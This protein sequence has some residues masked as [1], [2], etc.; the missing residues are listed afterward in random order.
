MN[1]TLSN[2]K[3][4]LAGASSGIG[5]A[6]A[7]LLASEGADVTITGR[8]PQKLA[9]SGLSSAVVDSRNREELDAFFAGIGSFDHLVVSLASRR[10][11][12]PLA[13]LSLADVREGFEEKFFAVAH[14]VQAALPYVTGSI[15]V[16]SAVSAS[17]RMPGTSGIAAVNGALEIMVPIWARELAPVRVNA[18]SPGVIDTPW[19]DFLPAADRAAAFAQYSLQIPL[20]RVG[21]A[22][23]IA[24]VVRS[25]V[26]ATYVTG[27]VIVADG[28]LG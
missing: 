26:G 20:K 24:D 19:W 1:N 9:A 28:G 22:E 25:L 17:A 2:Q 7:R 8:D 10:G 18:V 27:R 4:V 13:Q 3:I 14:T 21:R 6:S 23:E 11:L 12:G 16:L 15:T 5:L